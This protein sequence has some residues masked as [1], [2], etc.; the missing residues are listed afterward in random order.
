MQ[1]Y[2]VKCKRKREMKNPTKVTLTN[3]R[4]AHVGRC[5]ECGTE[6]YRIG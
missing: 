6:I 1:G 5:L 2:C 3:G 4:K